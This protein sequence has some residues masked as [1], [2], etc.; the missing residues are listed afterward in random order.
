MKTTG[1]PERL[2]FYQVDLR[3]EFFLP[4]MSK[5]FVLTR[6]EAKGGV[7]Q[8]QVTDLGIQVSLCIAYAKLLS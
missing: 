5:I 8:S 6:L 3:N 4:I 7:L 2:G 1:L